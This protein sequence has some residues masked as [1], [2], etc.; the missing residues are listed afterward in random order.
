M[1]D[2]RRKISVG[3]RLG[4]ERRVDPNTPYTGKERRADDRRDGVSRR[5]AR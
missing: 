4:E 2:E 5:S 3:R 1:A